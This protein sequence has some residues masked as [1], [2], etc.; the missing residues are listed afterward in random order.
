MT[1]KK[2]IGIVGCGSIGSALALKADESMS[3][4]VSAL[5]LFDK[6]APKA[7]ELASAVERSETAGSASRVAEISDIVVEAAHPDAAP[8][9]LD[10]AVKA[11]KDAMILSI[12][13]LI[14]HERLLAAASSAGITVIMPSGAVAGIDAVKAAKIAGISSVTLTTRKSPA[15]LE[16]APYIRDKGIDIGSI[17]G[18]TLIFEGSALEAVAAF[19]RNINVSALLSIAG[20][21]PEQTKVRIVT[22]PEYSRN[23]H[24]IRVQSAAG[25]FTFITENVPFP[26]NPKTSHLA[27]L[28]AIAALEEYLSGIHIGT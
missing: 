13:G 22:S 2:I 23:T 17:K 7:L 27:A 25:K 15:S 6:D 24:E 28:S 19:P 5:V 18:E 12:G 14:G 11:G 20:M 9:V 3:D 4:R 10:L 26:S 21:G 16:G 8:G 1:K